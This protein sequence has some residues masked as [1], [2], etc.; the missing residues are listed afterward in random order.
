LPRVTLKDIAREV[1]VSVMTV[2]NVVNGN[3]A[4]VSPETAARVEQAIAEHGYV[5]NA[6]AQ[7]LAAR[8]TRLVG[9]LVPVGDDEASLL[10]SPH[11]V[12]VAGAVEVELRHRDHH[13]MLR[14]VENA[15]D[16][17]DS[18]RRWTLDGVV[19]M[20][21]TDDALTRLD[22]PDGLPAV[23]IDGYVDDPRFAFV[24]S[25][26]YEGG[27]LAGEHLVGLGHRAVLFCGPTSGTSRVVAERLAGFRAAL[28]AHDVPLLG[29]VPADTTW[30]AGLAAGGRVAAEFPEATAVFATADVLA[31]GVVRGLVGAGRRVPRDVSVVGYD[32]ADL[33]QYVTPSLTTVRQDTVRK[34]KVAA[35][36]LLEVVVEE[37]APRT[38]DRI[39]V[40]LVTRESSA[41]AP[42]RA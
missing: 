29:V 19:V 10:V 40:E 24:R 35:D 27:R 30:E 21:F 33:A 39:A 6:A 36:L 38:G 7:S 28:D 2:S 23:I 42:R 9:L 3:S 11:D 16:V 8:R 13:L 4:R 12:A 31:A 18:V 14:G 5:P 17:L 20:G 25:D 26:D 37:R 15:A 22:L 34:G 1:G 41:R 32:D